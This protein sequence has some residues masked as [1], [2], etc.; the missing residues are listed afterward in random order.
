MKKPKIEVKKKQETCYTFSSQL[1]QQSKIF[2]T[3]KELQV[4]FSISKLHVMYGSIQNFKYQRTKKHLKRM[5]KSIE[6]H[7]SKP[8]KK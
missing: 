5:Q 4:M 8:P 1:L 7:I 6:V 2:H 3:C